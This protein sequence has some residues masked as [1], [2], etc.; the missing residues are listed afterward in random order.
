MNEKNPDEIRYRRQAFR[1]FERQISPVAILASIPRSHAWLFKWKRRFEE[2]GWAALDSL[3]KTPGS[4]PQ[5]YPARLVRLVI[6]V[7]QRLEK[8]TVGLVSARA[9][10]RQL[11]QR[12]R[13]RAIPAQTTIK[14]WLR[15]QGVSA[16]SAQREV[17]PYYPA[18]PSAAQAVLFACDWIA[19]YLPGGEKV[20]AF[21]TLDLQTHALAQTLA[22]DKSADTAC[23]HLLAACQLIGI[24]DLLRLDNDSAFTGLGYKTRLFGR[25]VRLA[26][27]LG[28]EPLFIAPG[29]ARRNHEVERV[30][31][32]WAGQFWEKNY[33]RTRQA[34]EK[35]T[36]QFLAWYQTYDPPALGGQSVAQ[37]TRQHQH[38]HL[39]PAQGKA[40]PAELLLTCGR[41]HFV[42]RVS[43][44]GE[45]EIL[46][47]QW[48]VS[49]T[50]SGQYALATLNLRKK[51][52]MIYH[53]RSAR[54]QA[55]LV[56]HYEYEIDEALRPLRPEYRRRL[57]RVEMLNII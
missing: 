12:H 9:I 6:R 50:L 33:F 38:Q 47:E 30:N 44:A 21:H 55:H 10:Q 46:K 49:R 22:A 36:P 56:R 25:F 53:R 2:Q 54:A 8:Q 48:K 32:L 27:W 41:L 1:F 51:E 43:E 31:G 11:R 39:R 5:P 16:A 29:E 3:P 14:R 20:Y 15:E 57:R 28:I 35:K 34:L 13:L 23:A 52:L 7:R 45:I 17:E 40:L 42:R 26:L 4:S 37:V 18:L 24:P 19:R